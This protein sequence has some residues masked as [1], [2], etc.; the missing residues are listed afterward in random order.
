MA[1]KVYPKGIVTFAPR[2]SDPA[3]LLAT[4][5]ISPQKLVDWLNENPDYLTDSEKYGQ[6]LKL[7]V[8]KGKENNVYCEVDA[9]KSGNN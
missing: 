2:S 1:E 3:Y 5:I 9:F 6:Q 8:K 7:V 4:I